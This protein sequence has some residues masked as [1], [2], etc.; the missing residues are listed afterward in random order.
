MPAP[1]VAVPT[2]LGA[3]GLVVSRARSRARAFASRRDLAERNIS[4][5][6]RRGSLARLSGMDGLPL[7]FTHRGDDRFP[8]ASTNGSKSAGVLQ[9]LMSRCTTIFWQYNQ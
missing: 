2:T 5:H 7:P 1:I 3:G 6:V 4:R 9:L 8:D